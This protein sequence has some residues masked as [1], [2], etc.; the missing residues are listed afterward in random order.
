MEYESDFPRCFMKRTQKNLESYK[1]NYEATQLIDS[2]LGFLIVPKEKLFEKIPITPL[3]ELCTTEW[4][5]VSTWLPQEIKCDLG[6]EHRLTLRQL[7][8]KLR[9]AVAH[10]HIQPYPKTGVVKG[11][12]FADKPSFKAKVPVAELNQFIKQLASTLASP[13]GNDA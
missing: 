12:E 3:N 1:G 11:F 2:L 9:N 7:V 8:R 10:C 4:G 5:N 6:H 13:E